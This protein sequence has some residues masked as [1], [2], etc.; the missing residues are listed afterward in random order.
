MCMNNKELR[1]TI[2]RLVDDITDLTLAVLVPDDRE[3]KET[4]ETDENIQTKAKE[5]A[6][7]KISENGLSR[8]K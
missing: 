8:E 1:E 7:D 5:T 6:E 2:K 4:K 3:T